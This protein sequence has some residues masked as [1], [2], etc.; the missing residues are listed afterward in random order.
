MLSAIYLWGSH[1]AAERSPLPQSPGSERHYLQV[2]LKHSALGLTSTHP[3]RHMHAIQAE[4]LLAYYFLRIGNFL[5]AR[6][7]S[8]SALSLA[9]GCGLH[10]IRSE[11][12]WPPPTLCTTG[13]ESSVVTLPHPSGPVEEGERIDGFWQVVILSKTLAVAIEVPA[14]VC[15]QLEAPG[16]QIDTPWPLDQTQYE[17]VCLFLLLCRCSLTF[18]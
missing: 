10:R 13:D 17:D 8:S 6:R 5:E 16:F 14:E 11:Y 7:H 18:H 9:I 2:A 12:T 3:D 15:G 1:L 4:V